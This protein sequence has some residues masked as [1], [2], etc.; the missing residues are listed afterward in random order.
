MP[1]TI[2]LRC[3]ALPRILSCPASRI[4]PSVQI[5]GETEDSALGTAAHAA[6]AALV[7]GCEVD[8]A[9]LAARYRADEKE[10]SVLFAQGRKLWALYADA[11][12]VLQVEQALARTIIAGLTL[13]GTPDLIGRSNDDAGTLVVL[14]WKSQEGARD[15]RDQLL[16][17]AHLARDVWHHDGAVKLI[18][19]YLRDGIS[20][21]I[22]VTPPMMFD[23]GTRLSEAIRHPDR[24]NPSPVNCEQ[25]FCP[26]RH[27][28]PA[29]NAMT[30][31][32][33]TA[34]VE[35]PDPA[36]LTPAQIGALYP[37]IQMLEKLCE[38]ARDAVRAKIAQ[39]GALPTGD[40][41]EVVITEDVR[42]KIDAARAWEAMFEEFGDVPF[43][44]V[45]VSKGAL[46]DAI[47][48]KAPKGQKGKRI[49][50]FMDKLRAADAVRET[51]VQKLS[52]RKVI[53]KKEA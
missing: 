1:D 29:R 36:A 53:Q 44:A 20:E 21:V 19:C 30:L 5:D 46:C 27:E 26:R 24:F 14:D 52:V 4:P 45:T 48:A 43:E 10:L 23:W 13:T 32:A 37:R 34:I 8:T 35:M 51:K 41:R 38:A 6:M 7:T 15:P 9:E 12:E 3:S 49:E 17:Y 2:E 33:V 22:D 11:I 50:A 31:A 42:E 16:G 47:G 25:S 28:C 40:G 39:H 18:V